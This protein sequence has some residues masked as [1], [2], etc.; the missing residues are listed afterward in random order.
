MKFGDEKQKKRMRVHPLFVYLNLYLLAL[1][2][3]D[4]W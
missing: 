1:N 3:V 2:D 4:S